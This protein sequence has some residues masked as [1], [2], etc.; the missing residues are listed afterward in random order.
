MKFFK[1]HQVIFFHKKIFMPIVT[2]YKSRQE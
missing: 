2:P 1:T